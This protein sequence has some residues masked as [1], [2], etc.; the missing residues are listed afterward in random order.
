[1][2]KRKTLSP[3]W[4]KEHPKKARII[5]KIQSKVNRCPKDYPL[6]DKCE[7]CPAEDVATE[8]LV[9]AHYDYSDPANCITACPSCHNWMDK[10]KIEWIEEI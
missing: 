5:R 1:M 4:V 2:E 8:N 6:K 9:H 7:L 3:T 10:H